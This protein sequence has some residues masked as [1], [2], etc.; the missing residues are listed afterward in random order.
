MA[1]MLR[2]IRCNHKTWFCNWITF[3]CSWPVLFE[4]WSGI[5]NFDPI[6]SRITR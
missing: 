2:K 4:K 6:C 1:D 3:Y 5:F